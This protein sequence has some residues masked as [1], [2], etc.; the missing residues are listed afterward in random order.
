[1]SP[2]TIIMLT[3]SMLG[4]LDLIFG[5]KFG[6]GAQFERGIML[7]GPMAMSMIGMLVLAPLI[8]HVLQ[9]VVDWI[10]T[11]LPI[12]PS[13]IPSMILAN[14]MGGAPLAL[15]FATNEGVGYFNGL[16]VAAM[17]GATVSFTLPFALGVVEKEKQE[18]LLL[19]LL[20]G[21][22]M[23][24]VGAFVAG[25][26]LKLPL[27]DLLASV[28]PLLLFAAVLAVLLFLFPYGC[29]KVFKIFGA[30]IKVLVLIGLGIGIFEA[31]S[32]LDIV[33]HT[34]PITEGFTICANAAIV[35][36]GAFPLVYILSKILEKPMQAVSRKLGINSTSALGLLST[37]ATCVT[38]LSNMKDMDEKGAML[39]SAF[40]VSA[41]FVFGGHLAFTMSINA[42]YV[43]GMIVGKLIAGIGALFVAALLYKLLRS[44]KKN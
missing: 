1:M 3:F 24:P 23:V 21:I 13:V 33:P 25:L 7:I 37:L 35:L 28:I 12:E 22:V 14:D 43:V 10:A 17:M 41:A 39:N 44:K 9:P 38:A 36:S 32:G 30:A 5:N 4:I 40:S 8:A 34:A 31:L 42:G 2:I 11:F 16:I 6:L 20:C 15:E 18:P 26:I 27:T 29:L 19:G